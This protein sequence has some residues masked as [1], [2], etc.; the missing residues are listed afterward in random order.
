MSLLSA[1]LIRPQDPRNWSLSP[2]EPHHSRLV[3]LLVTDNNDSPLS[4]ATV[5]ELPLENET[6]GNRLTVIH[7]P[8]SSDGWETTSTASDDHTHDD[9]DAVMDYTLQL[10]YGIDSNE[11]PIPRS[12]LQRLTHDFLAGIGQA[13][14]EGCE[15][16]DQ[17]Q[18]RSS[19]GFSTSTVSEGNVGDD[20][21]KGEKRKKLDHSDK[22][23]D[24][25]SDN[26]GYNS[27]PS[28]RIKPTPS[29]D[30]LRLSC[31]YRKRNPHR[32][33]VRDHHS[34]AMTYFPKFAELR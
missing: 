14:R 9:A 31:P 2:G 19:T 13:F 18:H 30:N 12:R 27:M 22:G 33:N 4:E 5:E 34:C 6:R 7:R 1:V 17:A 11:S 16:T 8:R 26:E 20:N 29:D 28:K 21:Q 32:F 15:D 25:V 10:V 23:A 24:D 3:K